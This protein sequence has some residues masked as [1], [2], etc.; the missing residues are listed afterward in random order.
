MCIR[1]RSDP[2]E[3]YNI[4]YNIS[5]LIKDS[6]ERVNFSGKLIFASSIQEDYGNQYGNAKKES[7]ELFIESSNR[8]K[9]D[10]CGLIIPNVFGPFCKPN[11]NSFISTFSHNLIH[12]IKTSIDKKSKVDLIYIDNLIDYHLQ[13]YLLKNMDHHNQIILICHYLL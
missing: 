9:Y 12:G 4:N 3:V 2:E 10:F 11:Y 8:C 5:K 6:I 7:R 13:L 1:D